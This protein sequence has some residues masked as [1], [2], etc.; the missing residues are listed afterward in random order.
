MRSLCNML[1][2]SWFNPGLI[3]WHMA[4][5]WYSGILFYADTEKKVRKFYAVY[6]TNDALAKNLNFHQFPSI[7]PAFLQGREFAQ[8]LFDWIARILVSERAICLWKRANNSHCSF[9]WA[10]LSR[11]LFFKERWRAN[12]SHCSLKKSDWAKSNGSDSLFGLKKRNNCEKL[13]NR[14][15]FKSNL[16]NNMSDFERKSEFPT[17]YF[18][19]IKLIS[20]IKRHLFCYSVKSGKQWGVQQGAWV[21]SVNHT[22]VEVFI[23]ILFF[24]LF[25]LYKNDWKGCGQIAGIIDGIAQLRKGRHS[26]YPTTC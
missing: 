22:K 5:I 8:R 12:W 17:L 25:C 10:I 18:C 2:L 14:S 21:E 23:I 13:S 6:M 26:F 4:I 19:H 16:I 15:F 11:S 1:E 9:T 20:V 7:W 24:T 3:F